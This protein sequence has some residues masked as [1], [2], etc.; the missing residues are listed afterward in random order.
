[1]TE[2]GRQLEV[3]V[4][5]DGARLTV[6]R[7]RGAGTPVIFLHGLAVNADLWDLPSVSGPDYEYRSLAS[8][9]NE[10]G[11]DLWLVNFRGHG[12]PHML[13]APAPG[14][15]D[16]SVD[17]FVLFDLP[18][19]VEHALAETGRRPFV[20]GASMGSMT[21]A[22]FAEGARLVG[23]AAGTHIVAD[24]ELAARRAG[25]LAGA[26]FVEFPAALR[27][28]SSAYDA[29]RGVDFKAL[30]RDFLRT[31]AD[32]NY[33]FE[34]LARWGWLEALISEAG[35]VPLGW[36]RR[37]PGQS[38]WANL[39]A[40]LSE[41]LAELERK[42]AQG[43]LGLAGKFSGATNYRAEVLLQGR[44]YIM[45]HM[46]AGVLAQMAKS[47]RLGAF[48]STLGAPDHVY[49]DHYANVVVPTLVVAGGRDRIANPAVTRDVFFE[50]IQAADKTFR[51]YPE[52]AHG[53]FEAAPIATRQ[54][55]PDIKSWLDAR[56]AAAG[57]P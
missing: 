48:V 11:Y 55:Y 50:R 23:E 42:V 45:D 37:E 44:R 1:V 26:V 6:K 41:S 47:V 40:P 12:A 21:L 56:D 28:P 5:E 49:S 38:W 31:D 8:I 46:K 3:V 52:I 57:N 16:W 39:P 2:R 9:L 24:A 25:Q 17:H 36:L 19:V 18:A 22:G 4:A 7:R 15:E 34:L 51:L 10:A 54:V 35:H 20:I 29:A 43:M 27:W 33:P 30:L 13:S 53:E 14:Q 32:A